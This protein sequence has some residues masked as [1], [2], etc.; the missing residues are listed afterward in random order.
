MLAN[1]PWPTVTHMVKPRVGRRVGNLGGVADWG[2]EISVPHDLD[3]K[4]SRGG[5]GAPKWHQEV[6]TGGSDLHITREGRG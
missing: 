3:A 4:G 6:F 1:V 5:R 2:S